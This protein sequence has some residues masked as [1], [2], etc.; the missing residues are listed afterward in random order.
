M[1]ASGLHSPRDWRSPDLYASAGR[2]SHL[3]VAA[4]STTLDSAPQLVQDVIQRH[5][6]AVV[7]SGCTFEEDDAARPLREARRNKSAVAG[8]DT[9]E[10]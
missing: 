5:R 8:M 4:L 3:A 6:G 2:A 7:T 10:C 9:V 1:P